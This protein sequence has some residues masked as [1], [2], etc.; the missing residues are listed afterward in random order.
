MLS[1]YAAGTAVNMTL[2]LKDSSGNVVGPLVTYP[3]INVYF[4]NSSGGVMTVDPATFIYNAVTGVITIPV[5]ATV[6]SGSSYYSLT[7]KVGGNALPAPSGINT[8]QIVVTGTLSST[9]T[10]CD[11]WPQTFSRATAQSIHCTPRDAYG[12]ALSWPNMYVMAGFQ[13]LS[14]AS[15][16]SEVRGAAN[17]NDGD[18]LTTLPANTLTQIPYLTQYWRYTVVGQPGGLFAGYFSDNTFTNDISYHGDV[19]GSTT[20][21]YSRIESTISLTGSMPYNAGSVRWTGVLAPP[22]S[23]SYFNV[24]VAA[25]GTVS[26]Y[27]D[28]TVRISTSSGSGSYNITSNTGS[29]VELVVEFVPTGS[30]SIQLN[31]SYP[32]SSSALIPSN[33]LLTPY[34]N[35][36]AAMLYGYVTL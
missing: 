4:T 22:A 24:I 13:A 10:T 23:A 35:A 2:V 19:R 1:Q 17:G 21:Y 30:N 7:V 31:C 14:N 29:P 3:T 36:G 25:T 15:I 20:V 11:S 27:L 26:V 16:L 34:N 5:L 18:Y 9:G 6:E 12:H 32:G 8:S 33:I 28:K